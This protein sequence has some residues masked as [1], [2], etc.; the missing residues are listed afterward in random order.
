MQPHRRPFIPQDKPRF[1]VV[2]VLAGL[3][4]LFA[5]LVAFVAELQG[6]SYVAGPFKVVFFVAWIVGAINGLGF[7]AGLL[8]G[9]YTNIRERPWKEQV[10]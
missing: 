2:F 7:T 10:W 4:G 8:T 3:C 9:K 5:G 6:L 1:W